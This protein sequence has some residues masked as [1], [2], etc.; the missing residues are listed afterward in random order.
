VR[1]TSSVP[2]ILSIARVM[3]MRKKIT[4][5]NGA[6]GIWPR[7]SENATN[8]RPGPLATSA[9]GLPLALNPRIANI[10][11]EAK[12]DVPQFMKVTVSVSFN[13]DGLLEGS[14]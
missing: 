4:D 5:Q 8:A 3:S 10:T 1:G 9:M 2:N 14:E 7:A 12:T 13:G 6:P 11:I